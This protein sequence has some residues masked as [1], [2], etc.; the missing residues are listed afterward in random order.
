MTVKRVREMNAEIRA[1]TSLKPA[2]GSLVMTVPAAV[3][4]ALG[5]MQGTELSV[6]VDDGRMIIEAVEP[7][8][9]APR[10]RQPKYTLDELLNHTS[11]DA[12][13]TDEERAWQNAA[14]VGREIW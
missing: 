13:M 3:R 14:P 6:S 8:K 5:Y 7:A 2:G 4:K 9:P 11:P 1:K 10:V 12:P